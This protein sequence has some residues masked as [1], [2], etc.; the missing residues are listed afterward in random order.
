MPRSVDKVIDAIGFVMLDQIR[1][2][3]IRHEGDRNHMYVCPAGFRTIGIG[4]NLDANPI[5]DEAVE[6]I[7]IDDLAEVI[8]SLNTTDPNWLSHPEP[9]QLVLLNL[10]FNLG[11]TR[12]KKFVNTRAAFARKDY[13][14]A[15]E[16]LENSLWY[17]QV[18][19]RAKELVAVVQAEAEKGASNA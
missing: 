6:Q 7:F 8:E 14:A 19:Q 17:R 11:E 18:G 10:R 12:W 9:I 16:G 4:H 1:E 2:Q 13:D 15:A 3:L 5:S